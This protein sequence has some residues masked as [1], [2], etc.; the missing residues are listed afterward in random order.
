[1]TTGPASAPLEQVRRIAVLRANGI[2]DFV[3]AVPALDA[4]RTTYPEAR[5]TVIGDVWLPGLLAGRPGP[6][7][8]ALVAPP[9]PGLRGLPPHGPV[10]GPTL[11]D[12]ARFL[13]EQRRARYDLAVQMHGG[14]RPSNTFV[15]G[16]GARVSVGPRTPDADPLDRTLPY[17]PHRHEVLRW[18]EVAALAGA[19]PGRGVHHLA[20]RLAVTE[21]DVA[22]SREVW[23]G[24]EPFVAV[25]VGARDVR[26]RWPVD[27][28][29]DLG[30]RLQRTGLSVVLVG[31][32]ADRELSG[33]VAGAVPGSHDLT[34]RLTLAGTIGLLGRASV[35]VGNDS[36]PRHLAAS[37]GT[38]TVGVFWVGNAL[39]F[40][41]LTGHKDRVLASFRADC[42]V[43][44]RRQVADRCEHD[45]SF[46]DDIAVPEVLTETLSL[47]E[48]RAGTC[49]G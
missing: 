3:M 29:V 24:D 28:F 36:G 49:T 22:Q 13:Q 15:R 39:S 5:I 20:P 14:G 42:P 23:P 27:C 2:G 47:L 34:G 7:D 10:D 30:R 9:Y 18:L 48:G 40:G 4:L 43:C 12:A 11:D 21:R 45:V 33:R 46:V 37:V 38:P 16:L 41:P 31:G 25:H 19:D 44:G 32:E 8:E 26:R 1:M 35:F 6:W 17:L